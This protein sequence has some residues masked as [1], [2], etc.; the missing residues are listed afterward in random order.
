ML[1]L[2]HVDFELRRGEVHALCGENGDMEQQQI[3]DEVVDVFGRVYNC[4]VDVYCFST[5]EELRE[6]IISQFAA[7]KPFD[8]FCPDLRTFNILLESRYL[9][10]LDEVVAQRHEQGDDFYSTAL[11]RGQRDGVQYALPVGVMPRL[12]CYD[13]DAFEGLNLRSP[14][15]LFEQG[16]WDA[17][18][19]A[20]CINDLYHETQSPVLAVE[21]LAGLVGSEEAARAIDPGAVVSMGLTESLQAFGR[22]QVPMIVGD[23]RATRLK[24]RVHWDVVP[25]PSEESD[26][27]R[28][29]F[30]LPIIAAADGEQSDLAREFVGFYVSGIGQKL[31]LERG[32]CLIPSLNMTFY[33]SMGN[34]TFPDHSNDYFFA[35]ENGSALD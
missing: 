15:D 27:S 20:A 4:R 31:R 32:E 34:V 23:L 12:I 30:E 5:A 7:G 33:T 24:T 29:V 8:V 18:G 22:G 25:F 9:S 1:A 17:A 13:V 14:Q 16:Q 11:K 3:V 2:D 21:D 6:R 35:I 10:P 28:S 26:F 19:F